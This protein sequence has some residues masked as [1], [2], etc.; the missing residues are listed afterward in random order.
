MLEIENPKYVDTTTLKLFGEV[1]IENGDTKIKGRNHWVGA[2]LETL[3]AFIGTGSG[4]TINVPTSNWYILLG[5][6]TKTL[7]NVTMSTLV[8]P[9]STWPNLKSTSGNYYSGSTNAVSVAYTA[10]WLPG[11][12]SG[13][14]GEIGLYLT[15]NGGVYPGGNPG[16]VARLSVADGS[17]NVFTVN[18]NNPLNIVW[19][20]NLIYV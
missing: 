6:D 10:V 12:V 16:M 17:F 13:N 4:T 1:E 5:T 19:Y 11:T 18:T 8:N 15:L 9:I 14:I 3:A 20:V 7:T 2:G